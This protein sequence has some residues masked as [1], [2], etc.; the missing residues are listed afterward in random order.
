M[1]YC[2]VKYGTMITIMEAINIER[3]ASA[4]LLDKI[5]EEFKITVFAYDIDNTL[6]KTNEF[7]W[8]RQDGCSFDLAETFSSTLPSAVFV[9]RMAHNLDLVYREGK[10]LPIAVKYKEALDRYFKDNQPEEYEKY[11]RFV[12]E[13]FSDFYSNVPELIQGTETL[14][15]YAL[16]RDIQQVFNSNAQ[17]H[18]TK[19]KVNVFEN[20]LGV[21]SLPYNAVDICY[22]KDAQSWRTAVDMVS[23]DEKHTLIWG[24][25]LSADIL[26]AI[27]AGFKHL[28]WIKGD[29]EKLPLE[30]RENP[31]IHIWCVDSIKDLL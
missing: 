4:P 31:D 11:L 2:I 14:L 27:E 12:E 3:E 7:Y 25:S 8:E 17:D 18:W 10:L 22:P 5:V 26:P 28:V 21:M 1:G 30:I 13:N 23:G 24:D 6:L 19:L 15:R 9:E 20:I 16:S 29:L